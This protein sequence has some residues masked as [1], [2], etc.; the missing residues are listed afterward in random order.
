MRAFV[1]K[2]HAHPSKI[3][4]AKEWPVPELKEDQIMVDVYSAGLNFFDV[5]H[6]TQRSYIMLTSR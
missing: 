4:L 2:E 1:V 6:H 3:S 5:S